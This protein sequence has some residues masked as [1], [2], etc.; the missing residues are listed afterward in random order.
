[1]FSD[2]LA[3]GAY[4]SATLFKALIAI[5]L[6]ASTSKSI[7]CDSIVAQSWHRSTNFQECRG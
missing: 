3:I 1:M 6:S 5:R 7:G 4:F 2:G